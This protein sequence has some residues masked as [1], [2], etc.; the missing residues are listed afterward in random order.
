MKKNSLTLFLFITCTFFLFAD[1]SDHQVEIKSY[2]DKK[3][4]EQIIVEYPCEIYV[5]NEKTLI[6]NLC[7]MLRPVTCSGGRP[8]EVIW[9]EIEIIAQEDVKMECINA[10]QG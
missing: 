3:I 1:C 7:P 9:P 4:V 2:N 5:N 6:E 8:V 10:I